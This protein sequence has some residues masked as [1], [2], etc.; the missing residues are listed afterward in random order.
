ML[1]NENS[2]NLDYDIVIIGAGPAGI[3]LS[4]QFNKTDLKVALVESG[5]RYYSENSQQYYKGSVEGDFP[6]DLDEARL[7]MFGGTTGHW[8]GSCRSLDQHDFLKWP[9]KKKI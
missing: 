8:G 2:K 3:T 4:L 6:R 5:E 7:S 1:A 9:I